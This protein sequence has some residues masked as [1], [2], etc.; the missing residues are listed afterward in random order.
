MGTS[1]TRCTK[2]CRWNWAGKEKCVVC[3]GELE[4]TFRQVY[5]YYMGNKKEKETKNGKL[6]PNKSS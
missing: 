4:P 1:V 3:G 5:D 6:S 2:C